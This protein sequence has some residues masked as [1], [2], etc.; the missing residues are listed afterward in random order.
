MCCRANQV[1]RTK[2][3]VNANEQTNMF[4]PQQL[5]SLY[6]DYS[7]PLSEEQVESSMSKKRPDKGK[8]PSTGKITGKRIKTEKGKG[9]SPKKT[10]ANNSSSK[11]KKTNGRPIFH[12]K[13]AKRDCSPKKKKPSQMKSPTEGKDMRIETILELSTCEAHTIL[14]KDGG[15]GWN[16]LHVWL[17]PMAPR[18]KSNLVIFWDS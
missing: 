16:F 12:K 14:R 2:A 3:K 15:R 5:N 17:S 6:R 11:I 10:R 7:G 1:P 13:N 4:D 8:T 18:S 9:I